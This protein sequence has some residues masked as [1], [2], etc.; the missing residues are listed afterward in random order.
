M[1]AARTRARRGGD[2]SGSDGPSRLSLFWSPKALA[3]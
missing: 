2:V 1:A 3:R